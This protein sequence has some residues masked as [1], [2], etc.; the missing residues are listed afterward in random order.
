MQRGGPP[1]ADL[2]AAGRRPRGRLQAADRCPR[3]ARAPAEILAPRAPR[4]P[5][6]LP[7]ESRHDNSRLRARQ[8]AQ[9]RCRSA[10]VPRDSRPLQSPGEHVWHACVRV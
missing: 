5:H 2:D 7:D 8:A 3:Q 4:I 9:A 10:Q 1:A 6:L